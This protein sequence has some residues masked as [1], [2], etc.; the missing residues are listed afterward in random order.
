MLADSWRYTH[1]SLH[2]LHSPCRKLL[3]PT[4]TRRRPLVYTECVD[5]RHT[6][7]QTLAKK[8]V[9]EQ[10]P[11]LLN[12]KHACAADKHPHPLVNCQQAKLQVRR[13]GLHLSPHH[14]PALLGKGRTRGGA[15]HT[16][17]TRSDQCPGTQIPPSPRAAAKAISVPNPASSRQWAG[18]HQR[19]CSSPGPQQAKMQ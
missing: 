4:K 10:A 1:M 13:W 9:K 8:L 7:A 19:S 3:H 6:A 18:S 15:L 5:T 16:P 11:E 14:L 17:F 2:C 12:A